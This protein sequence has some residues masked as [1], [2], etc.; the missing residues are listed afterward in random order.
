MKLALD[1][2]K[3]VHTGQFDSGAALQEIKFAEPEQGRYF[4]LESL[5]AHDGKAFAAVAELDL[6]DESGKPLSHEGWTIAYVDREE[7]HRRSDGQLLAH[8]MER[9][10]VAGSSASPD[11][12]PRPEAHGDRIPLHAS[13]GQR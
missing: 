13:P 5:N 7:C 3:P 4:C 6:L 11:P 10:A 2:A 9:D 12:R 8:R 1:T